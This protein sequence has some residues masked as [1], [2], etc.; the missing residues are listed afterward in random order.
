MITEARGQIRL[1][2]EYE[3]V[4]DYIVGILKMQIKLHN[5]KLLPSP[6]GQQEMLELHDQTTEYLKFICVSLCDRTDI[7]RDATRRSEDLTRLT[8]K[9]RARHLERLGEGKISPLLSLVVPD[10]ISAYR[11]IKDHA[12]N[13]AE[14][15]AGEK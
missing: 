11:R 10:M 14:V 7:R 8:K 5:N 4:S 9:F 12:L 6:E 13:I 2:D 1:A 3:S 15:V